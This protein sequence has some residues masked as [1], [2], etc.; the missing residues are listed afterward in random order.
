MNRP[1]NQFFS[2]NE[3]VVN[4]NGIG[5]LSSP[6]TK[7]GY[8]QSYNQSNLVQGSWLGSLIS[9]FDENESPETSRMSFSMTSPAN[10]NNL[11]TPSAHQSMLLSHVFSPD[12]M[13]MS[14]S[15]QDIKIPDNISIHKE[16]L[17]SRFSPSIFSPQMN[18]NSSN[19]QIQMEQYKR[20]GRGIVDSRAL[21]S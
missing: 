7:S 18:S 4:Q 8:N 9:P 13:T 1:K 5:E 3:T 10:N 20:N 6:T 14:F 15:G 19:H 21:E 17:S 12:F 16:M 2:P 11:G